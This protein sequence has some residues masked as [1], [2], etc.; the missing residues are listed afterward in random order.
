[1]MMR[2]PLAGLTQLSVEYNSTGRERGTKIFGFEKNELDKKFI[3][4]VR[5]YFCC[6]ACV[7]K[8]NS[9]VFYVL[10]EGDQRDRVDGFLFKHQLNEKY[11][12]AC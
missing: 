10:I 5:Q 12:V 9:K 7:E 4:K 8:L 11:Y 3:A 6:G 1:M 2:Q